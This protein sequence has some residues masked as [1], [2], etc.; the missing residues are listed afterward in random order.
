MSHSLLVETSRRFVEAFYGALA[1]G[2][3][4]GDAMLAGQR[5]LKDDNFR[6]RIFGAGELR[7]DD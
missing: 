7:L 1:R 6:G 2:K 3:R 5:Q 4:V